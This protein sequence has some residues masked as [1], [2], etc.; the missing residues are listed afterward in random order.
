MEVKCA[1]QSFLAPFPCKLW[2]VLQP[3][4]RRLFAVLKADVRFH[5]RS[6]YHSRRGGQTGHA[7][8]VDDLMESW[9][10]VTERAITSALSLCD[11]PKGIWSVDA[12]E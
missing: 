3:L 10:E 2:D 9:D 7:G 6:G 11:S 4:D 8:P 5:W 12:D 1:I